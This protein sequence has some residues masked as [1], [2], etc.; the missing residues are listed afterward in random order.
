M[1]GV[2]YLPINLQ[3]FHPFIDII[4]SPNIDLSE[5]QV[6]GTA[7]AQTGPSQR[8]ALGSEGVN[9]TINEP[10]RGNNR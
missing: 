10:R 6:I 1:N 2:N 4:N 5:R 8:W 9:Y 7:H 3:Q